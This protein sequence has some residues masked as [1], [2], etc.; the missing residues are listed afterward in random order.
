VLQQL[1][2]D[3]NAQLEEKWK[4]TKKVWTETCQVTVGRKTTQHKVWMTAEEE[5]NPRD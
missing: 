1:Y 5:E 3:Q 4:Q 2:D